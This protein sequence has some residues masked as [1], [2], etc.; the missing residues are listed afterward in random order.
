[1]SPILS[2]FPSS[3]SPSP[4]RQAVLFCYDLT[5]AE[6]F[7]NLEDWYRVASRTFDEDFPPFTVLIGNK[8]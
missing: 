5:N 4:L 6:S 1:M 3:Y 2:S 8:S 7:A